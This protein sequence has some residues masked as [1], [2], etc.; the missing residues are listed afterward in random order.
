MIKLTGCI[1]T[2]ALLLP[3]F[4]WQS[5]WHALLSSISCWRRGICPRSTQWHPGSWMLP[6]GVVYN[7]AQTVMS[8]IL[9]HHIIFCHLIIKD[10]CRERKVNYITGPDCGTVHPPTCLI[11][12]SGRLT[13]EIPNSPEREF[14]DLTHSIVYQNLPHNQT[15]TASLV[16]MW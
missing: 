7:R 8:R 15:E 12:L 5:R 3:R 6:L 9:H 2:R 1:S 16:I 13:F 14:I 10:F 4:S 11:I